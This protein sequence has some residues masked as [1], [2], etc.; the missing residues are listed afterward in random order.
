MLR[1]NN[2]GYL[3]RYHIDAMQTYDVMRLD[4][5]IVSL[6]RRNHRVHLRARARAQPLNGQNYYSRPASR[7]HARVSSWKLSTLCRPSFPSICCSHREGETERSR[8][9]RGRQTARIVS[10]HERI[11]SRRAPIQR[12]SFYTDRTIVPPRIA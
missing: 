1:S 12:G 10:F 11:L 6:I 8:D 5:N 3:A 9:V 2:G 4:I 7:V